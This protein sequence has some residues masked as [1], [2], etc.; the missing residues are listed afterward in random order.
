MSGLA[1]YHGSSLLHRQSVHFTDAF[2]WSRLWVFI[3]RMSRPKWKHSYAYA[4]SIF[5][6]AVFPVWTGALET[7]LAVTIGA[8]LFY[9]L[10]VECVMAFDNGNTPLAQITKLDMPPQLM[11]KLEHAQSVAAAEGGPPSPPLTPP[12]HA[13]EFA[14]PVPSP[15]KTP[16]ASNPLSGRDKFRQFAASQGFT[17]LEHYMV[18]RKLKGDGKFWE[19]EYGRVDEFSDVAETQGV[20]SRLEH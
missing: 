18:L 11:E 4:W 5:L 10:A 2:L 13:R 14:D 12:P 8:T 19:A 1:L 20:L 6:G 3:F 17:P 16:Q 7:G 9:W 15:R